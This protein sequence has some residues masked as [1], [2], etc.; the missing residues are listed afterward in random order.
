MIVLGRSVLVMG[1][2]TF[3]CSGG[4]GDADV[5]DAT[6]VVEQTS[7]GG[8]IP[9]LGG[10]FLV[11]VA[12]TADPN[13]KLQFIAT[14]SVNS[15]DVPASV[16]LTMQPLCTQRKQC[17]LGDPVGAPVTV[18]AASL[19]PECAASIGQFSMAIPG[20]ANTLSGSDAVASFSMELSVSSED[21]YCGSVSGSITAGEAE[22]PVDGSSF[23]AN[24]IHN[25]FSETVF[26]CP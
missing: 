19:S 20:G 25:G 9:A 10:D 17:G 12:T 11:I 22:I 26:A 8:E 7:C 3:A 13:A 18:P 5:V 23:G 6:V 16:S 24:R 1:F 14:T 15:T 2:A 4:G 21:F